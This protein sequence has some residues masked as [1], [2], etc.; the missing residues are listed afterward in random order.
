MDPTSTMTP[1]HDHD[2]DTHEFAPVIPLRRRQHDTDNPRATQTL[3][4][5]RPG[6][7]D[8]DAPLAGLTQR[9]S[10][11]HTAGPLERPVAS[12]DRPAERSDR[13]TPVAGRRARAGSH[14]LTR[15]RAQIA[16]GC[17]VLAATAAVL[18]VALAAPDGRP[19]PTR[20]ATVTPPGAL[21]QR[22]IHATQPPTTSSP[23]ITKR[24]H[25]P[26]HHTANRVANSRPP[27]T[28]NHRAEQTGRKLST[29]RVTLATTVQTPQPIVGSDPPPTPRP[30]AHTTAPRHTQTASVPHDTGQRSRA[31]SAC[32]PGELGC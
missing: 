16:A 3:E 19:H 8:P 5:D 31:A 18:A 1:P 2:A 14:R 25:H 29:R 10:A 26:R 32:V 20:T 4:A 17:A 24:R 21:G 28:A 23:A 13:A 11:R 12:A 15:R 9:V 27:R 22:K 6:I 30:T 7:W